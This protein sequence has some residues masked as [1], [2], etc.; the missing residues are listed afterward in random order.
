MPTQALAE[1]RVQHIRPYGVKEAATARPTRV[2]ARDG[3]GSPIPAQA[4]RIV[5][6]SIG[7]VS[8]I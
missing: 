4:R 8:R 7:S 5:S 3:F 1:S 2:A 6:A